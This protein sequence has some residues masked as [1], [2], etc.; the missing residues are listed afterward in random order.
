MD[1][2]R[3]LAE[4]QCP[5]RDHAGLQFLPCGPL[6]PSTSGLKTS[7]ASIRCDTPR[8]LHL[9]LRPGKLLCVRVFQSAATQPAIVLRSCVH[10]QR[11]E[12]TPAPFLRRCRS[13]N[14]GLRH[15][16]FVPVLLRCSL[17]SSSRIDS[18]SF[19]DPS[20]RYSGAR[21]S[22]GAPPAIFS[23]Y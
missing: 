7:G 23:R 2:I 15:Y 6:R 3:S 11:L 20:T 13:G 17:A 9:E 18:S 1:L 16:R 19:C 14:A 5:C 12:S 22:S 10:P 8:C 4:L 21:W